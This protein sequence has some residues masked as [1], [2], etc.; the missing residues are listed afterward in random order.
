MEAPGPGRHPNPANERSETLSED[1]TPYTNGAI[2]APPGWDDAPRPKRNGTRGLL[3]STWIGRTLR[4]EYADAGG[5][6]AKTDGVLLDWYPAGVVLSLSG[7]KTLIL[8]E[9]LALLE[10][11]EEA[12]GGGA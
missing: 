11:I 10:L 1:P 3:P 8:W 6:A 9:R 5:K 2:T 7:A 12:G 4:V